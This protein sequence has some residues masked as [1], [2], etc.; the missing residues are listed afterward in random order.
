MG[1]IFGF[2]KSIF[3]FRFYS[4]SKS[5]LLFTAM[6][7]LIPNCY[8]SKP[9]A[10]PKLRFYV[11]PKRLGLPSETGTL[12]ERREATGGLNELKSYF[13]PLSKSFL[14]I[15]IFLKLF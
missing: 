2:I 11:G 1:R 9:L 8:Y 10:P 14:F 6:L 12:L 7:S 3:C 13:N 4:Q 15:N 5:R